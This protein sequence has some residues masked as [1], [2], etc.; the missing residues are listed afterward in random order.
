MNPLP[1]SAASASAAALGLSLSAFLVAAAG[2]GCAV[3]PN[4]EPPNFPVPEAWS[5]PLGSPGSMGAGN[6]ADWWKTFGDPTLDS[7]VERTLKGSPDVRIA[8]ARIDQSRARRTTTASDG[9][10]Q[11][12]FNS[13]YSRNYGSLN[14]LPGAGGIP[15]AGIA[16]PFGPRSYDLFQGGFDA[17]WEIDLFGRIRRSIEAADADAQASQEALR[18]TQVSLVAETARNYV[19]ARSL[20]RRL[21]IARDNIAAQADS[22]ELART[23]F[24]AGLTS[25]LD[26]QQA[27]SLLATTTAQVP[28]LESRLS[29]AVHRLSVLTGAEPNALTAELSAAKPMPAVP[30]LIAMGVPGDVLRRRPDIR[31]AERQL[32]A[33]TARIGAAVAELFPRFT[34]TGNFGEQSQNF[35]NII[36]AGSLFANVLPAVKVPVLEFG[37]IRGNIRQQDARAAES[38][39][40][41]EKAVLNALEEAE[42]AIDAFTQDQ[43]RVK[44]LARAAEAN[45]QAV[46]LADERYGKGLTDFLQVL[47]SRRSLYAAQDT[48]VQG[49]QAVLTDLIALY[50]ALGGGWSPEPAEG[51]PA[52]PPTPAPAPGP[53]PAQ[54]APRPL[55]EPAPA[56][57]PQRS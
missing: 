10:P 23:R 4:Y 45:R 27:E 51:P 14:A 1:P 35:G 34:I 3:G 32:A 6:L 37:R 2:A 8:A 5:K 48:L 28:A 53:A 9:L 26:V 49:E 43:V 18:D 11:L 50:K 54:D 12:N 21:A 13:S 52:A 20:Q 36:S 19:E 22:L 24:R 15:G 47:D 31:R 33:D 39:A 56:P 40:S 16:F 42:N 38:L 7:L 25:E 46:I 44:S 41:Y 30:P 57:R 17:S 29:A 55:N